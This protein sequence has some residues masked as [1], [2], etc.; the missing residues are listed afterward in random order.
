[1]SAL[2]KSLA[3][4]AN[5]VGGGWELYTYNIAADRVQFVPQVCLRDTRYLYTYLIEYI[6]ALYVLFRASFWHKS[7]DNSAETIVELC[8]S[9]VQP[10]RDR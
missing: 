4:L 5:Q 6:L 1:M 10:P 3:E 9:T 2:N 7:Q 8:N